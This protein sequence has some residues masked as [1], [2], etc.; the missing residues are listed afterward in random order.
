MLDDLAELFTEIRAW[1]GMIEQR[2]G[3]F[4]VRRSP[5]LHFHRQSGGQRRADVKGPHG[6][7]AFDLP[8]PAP[9]GRRRAFVRALR[10]Y[11]AATQPPAVSTPAARTRS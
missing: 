1:P 11:Y 10:R 6:W 5:F 2:H 4:Y 3:V 8:Y 7:V 9:T